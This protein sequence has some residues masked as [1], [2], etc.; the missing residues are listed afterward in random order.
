M[1]D[2]A[3]TAIAVDWMDVCGL[4]D[5]ELGDRGFAHALDLG[6]PRGGRRDFRE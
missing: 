4:D 6:E 5:L 1:T 3:M 2:I